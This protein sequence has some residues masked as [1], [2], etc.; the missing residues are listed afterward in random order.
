MTIVGVGFDSPAVN[1]EWAAE[2]SFLFELWTDGDR[3]LADYYGAVSG[4]DQGRP[5]RVTKIL[6]ASGVLVL[7]Y[8]EDVVVGAHPD[9]VLTD[10]KLLFGG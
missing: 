1:A 2:E 4:P 7:E 6:D 9:E 8:N 5:S 3:Q 10:C